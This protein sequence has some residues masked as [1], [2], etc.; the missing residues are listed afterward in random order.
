MAGDATRAAN[1][2]LGALGVPTN[3]S[4]LPPLPPMPQRPASLGTPSTPA[5]AAAPGQITDGSQPMAGRPKMAPSYQQQLD[6]G[7][8]ET[9]KQEFAKATSPV[10]KASIARELSRVGYKGPE[11]GF[12][13][14]PPQPQPANIGATTPTAPQ[15][16][17]QPQVLPN[18]RVVIYKDGKGFSVPAAQAQDAVKQGYSLTK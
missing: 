17:V 2:N 1:P 3:G 10:D 8:V 14:P 5:P 4:Q 13:G 16:A 11:T 6:Q 7:V 18:G 12:Q 9:L 15:A